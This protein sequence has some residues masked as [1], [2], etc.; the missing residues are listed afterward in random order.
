MQQTVVQPGALNL[1]PLGQ[2]EGTLKLPRG[3][4]AMEENRPWL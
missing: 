1:D 4:A 2:H 3:N